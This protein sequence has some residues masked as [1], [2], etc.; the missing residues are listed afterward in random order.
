MVGKGP[1]LH[2][3]PA[4]FVGSR[5]KITKKSITNAGDKLSKKFDIAHLMGGEGKGYLGRESIVRKNGW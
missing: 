4:A 3:F 2:Q 1:S 5:R